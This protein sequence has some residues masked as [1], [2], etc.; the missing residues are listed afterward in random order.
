MVEEPCGSL[1]AV[2]DILLTLH[3]VGLAL[4]VGTS[5]A[6]LALGRAS[7]DLPPEERARFMIRAS[8]I[9]KNGSWGLLLLI[10]TGVA[11]WGLRGFSQVMTAA[12]GAFHAKLTLVVVLS[13]LLGWMQVL[14]KRAREAGGGPAMGT[15]P[16]VGAAM[17]VTGLAIVVAAV[18]A[19]H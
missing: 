16:K 11:M 12:G 17:L 18:L 6:A 10:A 7:R 19:F 4:G 5:F 1:R 2:Y 8:A 9:G 3:F 13:G 14:Q 15:I